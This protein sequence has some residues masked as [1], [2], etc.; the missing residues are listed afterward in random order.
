MF[1][2]FFFRLSFALSCAFFCSSF[3]PLS[4]FPLSPISVSPCLNRHLPNGV[5]SATPPS[6]RSVIVRDFNS[7]VQYR[8]VRSCRDS[9]CGCDWQWV[10]NGGNENAGGKENALRWTF[11]VTT[12][13]DER[14]KSKSRGLL[15]S[16]EAR[17]VRVHHEFR[18]VLAQ[19]KT[20]ARPDP[21]TARSSR[22]TALQAPEHKPRRVRSFVYEIRPDR[23]LRI[24]TAIDLGAHH[25]LLWWPVHRLH[26]ALK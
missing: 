12:Q 13:V 20:S 18:I 22:Q 14:S 26:E 21:N 19:P 3:L 25:L 17:V 23:A 6:H 2:F 1:S 8:R 10:V 4:F 16:L 24:P 5:Y 7:R 11:D 15:I 9:L